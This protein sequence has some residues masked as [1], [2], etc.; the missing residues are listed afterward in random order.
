MPS[1][2]LGAEKRT[3]NR[4]LRINQQNR[5]HLLLPGSIQNQAGWDFQQPGLATGVPACSKGVGTR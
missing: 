2:L 5:K 4:M 1:K 3:I